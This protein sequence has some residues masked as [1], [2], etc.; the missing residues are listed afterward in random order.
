MTR[1]VRLI[2]ASIFGCV[3]VAAAPH[4][5]P[6]DEPPA[7]IAPDA[8][9][10]PE[11]KFDPT[12]LAESYFDQSERFDAFLTYQVKRG[13]AAALFTITRRW[14]DG[15][16]EL[17][18]DI[19]EPPS[20]DKWALLMHENRRGSD[21]L[22]LYAGYATDLKVRRLAAAQIE[23][24]AVFELIAIGDYRP[25]VP[26]ELSYEAGPDESQGSVP[27]HMVIART[28]YAYLGFDRLEL[29]FAADQKLLLEQRFFRDSKEVRRLSTTLADYEDI[30]GRRIPMRWVAH[31]WADG[32][33]TEIVLKRVI[34]TADLPDRIF[35]HLNLREQR[36]PKF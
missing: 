4:A 9:P 24:Q 28:P 26:G 20:F 30:G 2:G 5:A 1:F 12:A 6:G 31:R 23:R 3:F 17:L 15:L 22:F 14:R 34:E 36:F 32:G 7:A 19:R 10:L 29:V 18:F 35:S 33:E 21:D 16:A 13:P 8:L 25:T 27:C 11:A